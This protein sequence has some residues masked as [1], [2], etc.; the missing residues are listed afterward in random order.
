MLWFIVLQ[1]PAARHALRAL[2][3]FAAANSARYRQSCNCAV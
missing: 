2:F 3:G 1:R